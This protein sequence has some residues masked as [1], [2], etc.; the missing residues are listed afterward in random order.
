MQNRAKIQVLNIHNLESVSCNAFF[1]LLGK[2]TISSSPFA[3]SFINFLSLKQ[4]FFSKV[5]FVFFEEGSA[6]RMHSLTYS[7]E[8]LEKGSCLNSYEIYT[9]LRSLTQMD[10]TIFFLGSKQP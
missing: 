1:F 9:K 7:L 3:F 2:L 10:V 4:C 6:L 8:S 5:G